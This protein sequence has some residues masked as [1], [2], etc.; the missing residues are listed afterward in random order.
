MASYCDLSLLYLR[1]STMSRHPETS[2]PIVNL[3][4]T[5]QPTSAAPAPQAPTQP[6][7]HKPARVFSWETPEHES[8]PKPNGWTATVIALAAVFAIFGIITE[9]PLFSVIVALAAFLVIVYGKRPA[10]ILA[11]RVADDGIAVNGKFHSWDA[12]SS[13]WAL[14]EPDGRRELRLRGSS[15]LFPFLTVPLGTQDPE[16]LRRFVAE[17]LPEREDRPSLAEVIAERLGF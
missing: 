17:H 9:N 10:E 11:V 16:T 6:A 4:P 14:V 1:I 3:R 15:W 12:F 13:F 5:T 2:E 7:V 8:R